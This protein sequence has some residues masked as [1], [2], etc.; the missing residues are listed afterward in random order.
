MAKKNI[1]DTSKNETNTFV[2]G[3]NK[4]SDPTYVQEGMWTH[5]RNASNNTFE[6]DVGS[7]SNESSNYL[8]I[9]AGLTMPTSGQYAV[10][11]KSLPG[12]AA[13]GDFGYNLNDNFP[14]PATAGNY[15][16]EMNFAT[17]KFKT[18]RL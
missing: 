18:T 15:K 11:N 2:K 4:D 6:G 1:Q 12:L 14:G 3:L 17:G 13:G 5:A 8:C 10:A 7:L 16:F 9:T